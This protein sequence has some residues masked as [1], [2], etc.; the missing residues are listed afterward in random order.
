MAQVYPCDCRSFDYILLCCLFLEE[1]QTIDMKTVASYQVALKE[2]SQS[3]NQF[4]IVTLGAEGA[5]KTT[6]IDILLNQP[7]QPDQQS[8]VGTSVSSCKVDRYLG[9]ARWEEIQWEKI[10]ASFRILEIP[11]K[12]KSELKA[13]MSFISIGPSLPTAL[14]SPNPQDLVN[15]VLDTV[16]SEDI[17][18]G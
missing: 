11:K 18:D 4:K 13:A 9:S 5:G 2:G 6:T 10:T 7:F 15:E 8:T 1:Q 3:S 17:Q 12:C 14:T 16:N